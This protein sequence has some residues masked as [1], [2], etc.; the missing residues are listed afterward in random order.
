MNDYTNKRECGLYY[1]KFR[2]YYEISN[3]EDI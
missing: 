3:D 2:D 1:Y